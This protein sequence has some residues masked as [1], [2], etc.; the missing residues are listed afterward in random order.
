MSSSKFQCCHELCH[1]IQAF[2]KLVLQ[3]RKHMP[4]GL[5]RVFH[6]LLSSEQDGV[7]LEI[8]NQNEESCLWS[9]VAI[10]SL[11]LAIINLPRCQTLLDTSVTIFIY[12]PFVVT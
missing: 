7:L 8:H 1:F 10:T 9:L 12:N 5:A 2:V 4:F 6:S 11:N 3:N